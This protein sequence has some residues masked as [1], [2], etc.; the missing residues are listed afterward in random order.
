MQCIQERYKNAYSHSLG[1]FSCE[2]SSWKY[3]GPPSEAPG[4]C[5]NHGGWWYRAMLV[6]SAPWRNFINEARGHCTKLG[7]PKCSFSVSC[8]RPD[9]E[10]EMDREPVFNNEPL[11]RLMQ[12]TTGMLKL[13]ATIWPQLAPIDMTKIH[14]YLMIYGV[15]THISIGA[16]FLPSIVSANRPVCSFK[17]DLHL[18]YSIFQ[19]GSLKFNQ[20]GGY[21]LEV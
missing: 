2:D 3:P 10:K 8:L 15:F 19:F 13:L 14:K 20:Q 16:G 4:W 17:F 11:G 7:T 12:K 5:T 9:G 21:S 18:S 6:V 1:R